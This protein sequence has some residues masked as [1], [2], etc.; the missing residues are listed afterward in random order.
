[1]SHTTDDPSSED[2]AGVP[3][4]PNGDTQPKRPLSDDMTTKR[5]PPGFDR[6][7]T[8][9]GPYR[10]LETIGEGGMGTVYLAEQEH[11]VRRRVALKVIKLGMDTKE[12]VARFEAERQA[13]ALMDH[14]NIAKVFDAGTTEQGRPYFVMEYVPGMRLTEYCDRHRLS[15]KERLGLFSQVCSAINHAHQK[16]VIHRDVK[17]SN[18][19]VMIQDDKPVPKV[20]DFGVAK[21]TSHKLT[22]RTVFTE[23]GRLIGTPEYMSPEQAEMTGLDVDIRT[24]V[25][26]LGVLLYELL[27]GT[28]PFDP[29]TLRALGYEAIQRTIREQEPQR[30]ST[31]ITRLGRR[32]TEL[33]ALRRMSVAA[34]RRQIRGELDWITLKAME[35][36]RTRRYGSVSELATDIQRYMQG[37]PVLAGPPRATYRLKKYVTKHKGPVAA[38]AAILAA[39]VVFGT[40][41]L[42]QGQVASERAARIRTQGILTAAAATQDPLLKS[43]LILE[44]PEEPETPERLQ[45]ARDAA[46]SPLPEFVFREHE[47]GVSGIS[48]SPNGESVATASLDGT[49]RVWRADGTG[50]TKVF[51]A[52]AGRSDYPE[53]R[54][55][56][57]MSPDGARIAAT[58]LDGSARIRDLRTGMEMTLAPPDSHYLAV[59]LRVVQGVYLSVR[60]SPD[61]TRL[62]TG[63]SDGTAR[64]WDVQSG[65][66]L[67][68]LDGH[69]AEVRHAGFSPDGRRVVTASSDGTARIW[70]TDGEGEPIVFEHD[71][72]V[73]W[74]SFSPDGTRIVTSCAN[75]TARI[76]RADGGGNPLVLQG[77]EAPVMSAVFSPDGTQVLTGSADGTARMWRSDGLAEALVFSGHEFSALQAVFGG[78]GQHIATASLDGT[79]RVWRTETEPLILRTR[80]GAVLM[81][82]SPDSRR[83]LTVH[84][85]TSEIWDLEGKSNPILLERF[86]PPRP[87]QGFIHV[88]T[89]YSHDGRWVLT[90][91]C[92][93][94]YGE[95]GGE[96]YAGPVYLWPADGT[97]G[98]LIFGSGTGVIWA[99]VSD[100]GTRLAITFVD[101]TLR[102][103]STDDPSQPLSVRRVCDPGCVDISPDGQHIAVACS[104]TTVRIYEMTDSGHPVVLDCPEPLSWN[105]YFSPNGKQI[106]TGGQGNDLLLWSIDGIG[107]PQVLGGHTGLVF[108]SSFNSDGR[109]LASGSADGTARIWHLDGSMGPLVLRHGEG[110]YVKQAKPGPDGTRVLTAATDGTARVWSAES[111][112]QLL[113]LRAN[114]LHLLTADFAPDGKTIAT[115]S[116]EGTVRV[117]RRF[118]WREFR[119]YLQ[120]RTKA[121]L[122]PDQRM[123][124]LAETPAEAWLAYSDCERGYGRQALERLRQ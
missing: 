107:E 99:D 115:A 80:M 102:I 40:V 119:E 15:N 33:A 110:Y 59:A 63:S 6:P 120:A 81:E 58:W 62:V 76:W 92:R 123:K 47:A 9:I 86:D 5:L 23:Q 68:V 30:P 14:P 44:L 45:I 94:C 4:P 93:Y 8:R 100:D 73:L 1:M 78:D 108:C 91:G 26:S 48:T 79:A 38:T 11:P 111:G 118:S 114:D 90:L 116:I 65:K 104:D 22:E 53:I 60:F 67:S 42:W 35:K 95:G 70:S 112:E 19:L 64:I 103:Y 122:T 17:P 54:P 106:V 61:G 25:Y 18:V 85:Y 46:A 83:L 7:P 74:A 97:R 88:A 32:A 34:L 52:S 2:Q 96:P 3:V 77:H 57:D 113:T 10:I 117:W 36:D 56:V 69:L 12:V 101:S 50:K 43:L 98:P 84:P 16:A 20:I 37:D 21:A 51:R 105:M 87:A 89:K 41:A 13:L 28:L 39:I 124:F 72:R 75:K 24:D 109:I 82:F 31:R 66:E 55:Q 27:T 29:K 71:S 49:V 121:C